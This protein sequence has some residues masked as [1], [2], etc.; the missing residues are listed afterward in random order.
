M[1]FPIVEDEFGGGADQYKLLSD[2]ADDQGSGLDDDD[3]EEEEKDAVCCYP[4][5]HHHLAHH[6]V[7]S[8]CYASHSILS[9]KLIH[10]GRLKNCQH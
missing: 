1:L 10:C 3:V 7:C 5:H 8:C 9:V 6:S 4:H 2:F